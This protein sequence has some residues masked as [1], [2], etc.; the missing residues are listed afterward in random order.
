MT[1]SKVSAAGSA[2]GRSA[3]AAASAASLAPRREPVA[4]DSLRSSLLARV[5]TDTA[6]AVLAPPVARGDDVGPVVA[7]TSLTDLMAQ[8]ESALAREQALM[9]FARALMHALRRHREFDDA[10]AAEPACHRVWDPVARPVSQLATRTDGDDLSRQH[11]L[12]AAFIDLEHAWG[13]PAHALAAGGATHE[14]LYAFL[15][16]LAD[17][18]GGSHTDWADATQPGCLI[19]VRA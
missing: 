18:M 9:A 8:R 13:T 3:R 17:R 19:S 16:E 15:N 6:D 12:L 14:R 2:L 4:G 10:T 1:V 7:T 5:L 11:E